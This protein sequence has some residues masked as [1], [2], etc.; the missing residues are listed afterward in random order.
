MRAF[1][2]SWRCSVVQSIRF[3]FSRYDPSTDGHHCGWSGPDHTDGESRCGA[4]GDSGTYRSLAIHMKMPSSSQSKLYFSRWPLLEEPSINTWIHMGPMRFSILWLEVRSPV[5]ISYRT[6]KARPSVSQPG[7]R[8]ARVSP[9][10]WVRPMAYGPLSEAL[11]EV[12]GPGLLSL[13]FSELRSAGLFQNC[14]S[15][16]ESLYQSA[17]RQG[18]YKEFCHQHDTEHINCTSKL[19]ILPMQLR[20]GAL[21]ADADLV[22]PRENHNVIVMSRSTSSVIFEGHEVEGLE[23][24]LHWGN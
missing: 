9:S 2:Q 4:S 11:P 19:R 22:Q 18:P 3:W 16:H 14:Q 6:P 24:G 17:L 13:C 1:F 12:Y 20:Q 23:F 5:T 15:F 8:V 7:S 21:T 10:D